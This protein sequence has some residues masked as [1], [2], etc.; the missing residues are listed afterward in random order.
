MFRS[1]KGCALYITSLDFIV[2]SA[3]NMLISG[4][5]HALSGSYSVAL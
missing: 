1:P 5:H 3:W 4:D 2:Q